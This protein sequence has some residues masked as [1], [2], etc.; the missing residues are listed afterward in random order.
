MKLSDAHCHLQDVRFGDGLATILARCGEFGIQRWMVNATRQSDWAAV[1]ALEHKI[2]G[3]Q[4]SFGLHP[5]WQNERTN[6]WL[7]DLER[8]LLRHPAAGIG[9]TGLDRWMADFDFED[10]LEVLQAHLDLSRRLNRP[11]SLH[12]LLAWPELAASVKRCS[13]SKRGFL[14]HSF[15]GPESM[16]EQWVNLGAYFSFSPRFLHPQK[17]KVRECFKRIPLERLLIE[18]DAPD[19]APPQEIALVRCD[20]EE[21]Q[22][23][24]HPANLRLCAQTL[25][26]DRGLALDAFAIQL[27]QNYNRLFG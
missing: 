10:Q 12:C 21:A 23:F 22:T 6:G 26:A 14:L 20:G 25:A 8:L 4:C 11:I 24:N 27:E 2:A 16:V 1:E 9:E 13:P 19:M 18:T 17:L 3:V 7:D 5:W 15:A